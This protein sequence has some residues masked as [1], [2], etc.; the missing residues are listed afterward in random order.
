MVLSSIQDPRK[1]GAD[2]ENLA[3]YKAARYPKKIKIRNQPFPNSSDRAI[4]KKK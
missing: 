3:K 2:S 4:E 1:Y